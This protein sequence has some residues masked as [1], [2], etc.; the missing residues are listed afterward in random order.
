MKLRLF[1]IGVFIGMLLM[2]LFL[3]IQINTLRATNYNIVDG[4][5]TDTIIYKK[6]LFKP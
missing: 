2:I 5:K 4:C 1:L 3:F 6:D